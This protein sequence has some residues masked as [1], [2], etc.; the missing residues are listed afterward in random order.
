[1]VHAIVHSTSYSIYTWKAGEGLYEASW[2]E[3]YF[4][5]GF[6]VSLQASNWDLRL[7][8]PTVYHDHVSDGRNVGVRLASQEVRSVLDLPHIAGHGDHCCPLLV[9]QPS[10][11][12]AILY[13]H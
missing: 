13:G 12:T 3:E 1:M 9:S 5:C 2:L 6:I 7:L 8:T 11:S 4:Y 10:P